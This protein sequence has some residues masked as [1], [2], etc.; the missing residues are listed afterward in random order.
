MENISP[1]QIDVDVVLIK[2][3]MEESF[4]GKLLKD[5]LNTIISYV[6]MYV[7]RIYDVMSE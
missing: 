1:N 5:K 7:R 2:K 4:Q 6:C 3:T